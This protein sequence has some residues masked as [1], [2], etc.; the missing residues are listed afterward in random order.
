[1]KKR[2]DDGVMFDVTKEMYENGFIC[3]KTFKTMLRSILCNGME[4]NVGDF[5]EMDKENRR[6]RR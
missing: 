3:R 2:Y 4:I 1:M 6:K 5:I